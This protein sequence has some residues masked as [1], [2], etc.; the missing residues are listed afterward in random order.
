MKF[1]YASIAAA[2][3]ACLQ[4]SNAANL[5]VDAS[6]SATPPYDNWSSA[7]HTIGTALGA[8]SAGDTVWVADGVYSEVGG[9]AGNWTNGVIVP[10]GVTLASAN[11]PA[12][13]TLHGANVRRCVYLAGSNT[14][15]SGFTL[16]GGVA[17]NE[18]AYLEGGG[19]YCADYAT[20]TNC[21]ITS[22]RAYR[23]GGVY[24]SA[25]YLDNCH[26]ID[27]EALEG[28]GGIYGWENDADFG[29]RIRS[30]TVRGNTGLVGAGLRGRYVEV[31]RC[32]FSENQTSAGSYDGGA[33]LVWYPA[34]IIRNCLVSSNACG[35]NGGGLYLVNG[36]R[37]LNC[38]IVA[39]EAGE[40]GGGLCANNGA[41]IINTIVYGNS[42]ATAGAETDN[43]F[44]LGSATSTYTYCCTLP[45]TNGVGN[46]A[47]DPRA[48]GAVGALHAD[49]PCINAGTNLPELVE[50]FDVEGDA[51]IFDQRVDIGANE[52]YVGCTH[53]DLTEMIWRIP[54]GATGQW[55]YAKGLESG[56][57]L[58]EGPVVIAAQEELTHPPSLNNLFTLYRLIW[59]R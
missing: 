16:T 15:L 28:G 30:C 54:V 7:A 1:P 55:Q 46:L 34:S 38:T 11:G 33:M 40:R 5:Y 27:N 14:V 13:A 9:G 53:C 51:R 25:G 19:A 32:V 21:L 20:I 45:L 59:R 12:A 57:W 52:T 29:G 48:A 56:E 8:A 43:L 3:I 37:V 36:P 35:R 39:N 10:P 6:G 42:D 4:L 24:V 22:N 50:A 23:G 18:D 26:V 17:T 58:D 31:D 49:S 2:T 47:A 41:D 44:N